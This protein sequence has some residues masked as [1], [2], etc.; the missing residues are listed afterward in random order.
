MYA[1]GGHATWAQYSFSWEPPTIS[2]SQQVGRAHFA[3]PDKGQTKPG[4][5]GWL[6]Q[7]AFA[8]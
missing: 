5:S 1:W 2:K 4:E 3:A 6:C 7:L 8:V